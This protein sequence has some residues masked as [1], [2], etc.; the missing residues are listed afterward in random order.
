MFY[1]ISPSLLLV[2]ISWIWIS[3]IIYVL[4][5]YSMINI[6]F[7]Q[8]NFILCRKIV[9]RIWF[10]CIRTILHCWDPDPGSGKSTKINWKSH[11]FCWK[12]SHQKIYYFESQAKV[13][14]CP[15]AHLPVI[16][17]RTFAYRHRQKCDLNLFLNYFSSNYFFN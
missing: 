13:Q 10:R 16:N 7:N 6:F 5:F 9:F 2:T 11:M 12:I 1:V 15:V 17:G 8:W 14:F 4:F 3:Y